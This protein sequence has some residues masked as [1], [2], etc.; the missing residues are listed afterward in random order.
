MTIE[1]LA[2]WTHAVAQEATTWG[3]FLAAA[4]REH[5]TVWFDAYLYTPG[6]S[7]L[8]VVEGTELADMHY[9]LNNLNVWCDLLYTVLIPKPLGGT[10]GGWKL[11]FKALCPHQDNWKN[12]IFP[13]KDS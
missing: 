5:G 1:D 12:L 8:V 11:Y 2:A 3:G 9:Y 7:L 10:Y 6:Q 4:K 13:K